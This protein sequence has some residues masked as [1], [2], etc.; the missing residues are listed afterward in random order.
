MPAWLCLQARFVRLQRSKTLHSVVMAHGEYSRTSVSVDVIFGYV[1]PPYGAIIARRRNRPVP[2]STTTTMVRNQNES[3]DS[4]RQLRLWYLCKIACVP[5]PVTVQSGHAFDIR[6]LCC[7]NQT[8]ADHELSSYRITP[9][10]ILVRVCDVD[11]NARISPFQVIGRVEDRAISFLVSL[12]RRIRLFTLE[13]CH[14]DDSRVLDPYR[15]LRYMPNPALDAWAPTCVDA[16][17]T[18]R[19]NDNQ[20]RPVA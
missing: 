17:F 14:V 15:L 3:S 5:R 19:H 11:S 9:E 1:T 4:S 6:G 13:C 12:R 16:G 10:H 20:T 7:P 2:S 8:E 18:S